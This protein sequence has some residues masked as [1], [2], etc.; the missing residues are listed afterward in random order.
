VSKECCALMFAQVD[1][2]RGEGV[3]AMP[4]SFRGKDFKTI[5]FKERSYFPDSHVVHVFEGSRV[6]FVP[7]GG[8]L[9]GRGRDSSRQTRGSQPSRSSTYWRDT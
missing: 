8:G 4:G 3:D 5:L 6:F 7:P 1:S 2:E 9:G